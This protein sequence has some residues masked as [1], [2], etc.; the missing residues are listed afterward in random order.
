MK[1]HAATDMISGCQPS[2][3]RPLESGHRAGRGAITEAEDAVQGLRS[4]TWLAR[5]WRGRISTFGEGSAAEPTVR[6][7]PEFCVHVEGDA[8][9]GSA[10][11]RSPNRIGCEAVRNAFGMQRRS[12]SKWKSVMTDGSFGC[13]AGNGRALHPKVWVREP[14]RPLRPAGHAGTR[15]TG[16]GASWLFGV[17]LIRYGD[18]AHHPASIARPIA[19]R[20][21]EMSSEKELRAC[22]CLC[23][24]KL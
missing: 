5:T 8:G 24:L 16:G 6:S 23:P 15:Q 9:S 17:R 2:H 19:R 12:G 7:A 3:R 11:G 4:S 22:I 21:P 10:R 14:R 18:R 20:A 13:G 1:F